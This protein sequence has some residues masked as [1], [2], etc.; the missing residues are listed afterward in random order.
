MDR[1][2]LLIGFTRGLRRLEIVSLDHGKDD[3]PDSGSWV[4]ILEDGVLITLRGKTGWREVEIARGS[5]NQTCPAHSQAYFCSACKERGSEARRYSDWQALPT[6]GLPD[7][8]G[9]LYLSDIFA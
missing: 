1:A 6:T 3:T 8:S 2:I 5:S 9:R 4:E 7:C